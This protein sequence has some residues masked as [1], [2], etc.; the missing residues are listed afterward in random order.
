MTGKQVYIYGIG[1]ADKQY[2]V[3]AYCFVM[4]EEVTIRNIL[5]QAAMLKAR[6]PSVEKVYA[7]DNYR[8]LRRDFNNS[9][10]KNTIESCAIFKN[11]L[12]SQG[13]KIL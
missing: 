12:E 13:I 5:Y 10:R 11:I 9:I 8:G 3:L 4:D 1:G 7:I 2:K 6:N